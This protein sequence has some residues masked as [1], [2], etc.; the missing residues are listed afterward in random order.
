MLLMLLTAVTFL[1]MISL[2]VAAHEYGHFLLARLFGM[3]VEEFAIGFGKSK[4]V[5]HRNGATE[6]TLRAWPLGGFVRIKGMVPEDDGSEVN[7]PNG[8]FSKHPFKRFVVLLAGPL[9]SVLAGVILLMGLFLGVARHPL[10]VPVLGEVLRGQAAAKAG[11]HAGDTITAINGAP[12]AT[13]YD[14]ISKVRERPNET[15]LFAYMRGSTAGEAR[16]TTYVSDVESP[17]L[18]K[19]LEPTDKKLKHAMI[20]AGASLRRSTLGE[21]TVESLGYPV[22]MMVGF[23]GIFT[24]VDRFMDEVGGPIAIVTATNQ[25]VKKGPVDVILLAALLSISLGI[26]NLLPFPPLDGGQMAVALAEL[27]RGGKRLSIR[28]QSAIAA[29]GFTLVGMLVIS[30]FAVDIGRML[31]GPDPAAKPAAAET[32]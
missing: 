6:Y 20:G 11:L 13:W 14:L 12:V 31:K 5:Y 8:F 23:V 2:L 21:A 1:V 3:D 17:V 25:Q 4:W 7:V 24:S 15:L 18:D 26:F 32:Q 9:F 27:V 22:R 10:N 29:I 30:V 28:T 19:N 16:V